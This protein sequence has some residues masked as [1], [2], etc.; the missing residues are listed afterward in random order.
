MQ[1]VE[2]EDLNSKYCEGIWC[3]NF[4][5]KVNYII[6]GV[7]YRRLAANLKMSMRLVN[8]LIALTVLSM[9]HPILIMG[10]FNYPGINW[11]SL[12]AD[13]KG[14]KFL[15]LVLDCYLEQ[16]VHLPTR[17]N[18]ILDLVLTSVAI[19]EDICVLPPNSNSDHNILIWSMDCKM[20][21]EI[22]N[23]LHCGAKNRA[24]FGGL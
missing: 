17:S 4:I 6:V 11:L 14:D 24:N 22:V 3:K 23:K 19:K 15:K 5:D 12:T 9:N 2:C 13:N 7:C 10:D 21:A 20:N 1:S 16:Q 8:Y 18:N